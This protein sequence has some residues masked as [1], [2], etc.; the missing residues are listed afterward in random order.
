MQYLTAI[1]MLE[2]WDAG[3][4]LSPTRQA[5][6]LLG[7]ACPEES[8]VDLSRLSIGRRDSRLL[9]LRQAAFGAAVHCQASCPRCGEKIESTFAVADILRNA[10]ESFF[11][12]ENGPYLL[13]CRVPTSEDL[14]LAERAQDAAEAKNILMDRCLTA[15]PHG[16]GE[17]S[18]REVPEDLLRAAIERMGDEDPQANL[19]LAWTCP[20][21]G[22]EWTSLF[23]A[24]SFFWTEITAWAKR[25]VRDVH[26]LASAYGWSEA[27]IVSMSP[28]RRQMYLDLVNS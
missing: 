6:G 1:E 14:L 21:C 24:V 17:I 25:L 8:A 2:V 18:W 28:Y 3:Q 27:A 15:A 13:E 26:A 12:A 5:L 22:H 7:A 4:N 10:G 20:G 16:G 19:R 23:D 11:R 9:K